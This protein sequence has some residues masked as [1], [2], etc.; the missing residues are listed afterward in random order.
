MGYVLFIRFL[1]WYYIFVEVVCFFVRELW[2]GKRF[3]IKDVILFFGF[4][5]VS[6][7]VCYILLYLV[8]FIGIV[9]FVIVFCCFKIFIVNFFFIF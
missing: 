1:L 7:K 8:D 9:I 4:D 6:L 2:E 3:G 5:E